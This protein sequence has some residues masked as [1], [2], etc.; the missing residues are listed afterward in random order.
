MAA[1]STHSSHHSATQRPTS[2]VRGIPA[3]EKSTAYTTTEQQTAPL[4]YTMT[5]TNELPS[6]YAATQ[7]IEITTHTTT[8]HE[9]PSELQHTVTQHTMPAIHQQTVSHQTMTHHTPPQQHEMTAHSGP[10]STSTPY[11]ESYTQETRKISSVVV[12]STLLGDMPA[13]DGVRYVEVPTVEEQVRYV[14][15]KEQREI[16]RKVMKPEIEWVERVVY[17]PTIEYVDKFVEK[18]QVQVRETQVKV[19]RVVEV[20]KEYIVEKKVQVPRLREEVREVPGA[21]VVRPVPYDVTKEV[22]QVRAFNREVPVIVA[23]TIK[24][25]ITESTNQLVVDALHYEPEIVPVDVHLARPVSTSLEVVGKVDERHKLVTVSAAQYNTM[26][27]ALNAE[28]DSRVYSSLPFIQQHGSVPFCGE[29]EATF[30]V[31][32]EHVRIEG[33]TPTTTQ[34]E[35]HT[36]SREGEVVKSVHSAVPQRGTRCCGPSAK[37]PTTTS[38][39]TTSVSAVAAPNTVQATT[40]AQRTVSVPNT[41]HRTVA[42]EDKTLTYDEQRTFETGHVQRSEA[43]IGTAAEGGSIRSQVQVVPSQHGTIP[44]QKSRACC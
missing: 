7:P 25:V 6:H 4:V 17:V 10:R 23:Q 28:A 29:H 30:I 39:S 42:T 32:P 31:A 24:P 40:Y 14:T 33:W 34:V 38:A 21:E 12:E 11:G 35:M 41:E 3:E 8:S 18:E 15:R 5:T 20:P 16:E 27:R 2:I 36:T 43:R 37:R 13:Q 9:V 44:V 22:E 26:L 1:T 19:P